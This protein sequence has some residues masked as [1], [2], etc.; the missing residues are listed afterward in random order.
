[1]IEHTFTG[2]WRHI[3]LPFVM[4]ALVAAVAATMAFSHLS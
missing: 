3:A 2:D 4:T 1:M